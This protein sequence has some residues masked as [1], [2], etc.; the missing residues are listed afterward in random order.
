MVILN[1]RDI[2]YDKDTEGVVTTLHS[3][4]YLDQPPRWR[5]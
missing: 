2:T 4:G 1:S 3:S 5:G